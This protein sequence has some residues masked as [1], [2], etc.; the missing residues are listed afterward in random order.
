MVQTSV[1]E[2]LAYGFVGDFYDDSPRRVKTYNVYGNPTIAAKASGTVAFGT[3]NAVANDTVTVGATVYKFVVS[4]SDANDVK[5]GSNVAATV[6]NLKAAINGTGTAGTDYGTGT[7]A[8]LAAEATTIASGTLTLVAKAAG[9]AGNAIYL[10]ASVAT[11]TAFSG[12]AD[13]GADAKVGIAFTHVSGS[14]S[15]AQVGTSGVFAGILVNPQE[16]K[17]GS[18]DASLVVEN[19]S[20]GQLCTMGHVF[21]KSLTD[22]AIGYVVAYDNTTGELSGYSSAGSI[23]GTSTQIANA[24]FL[25]NG[26]AGEVVKLELGN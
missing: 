17:R 6:A 19:N 11:A 12:G 5:I 26:T 18:L 9:A 8:N 2:K 20:V 25:S 23:P 4:P 3:T 7:V 22:V 15:K 21:V 1:N 24:R 13:K 14:E 16:M 10:A